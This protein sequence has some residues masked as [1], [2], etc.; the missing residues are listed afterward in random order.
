MRII[1]IWIIV[2]LFV[3]L[4]IVTLSWLSRGDVSEVHAQ[5]KALLLFG[6]KEHETFLG[7]L[8][9]TNT[10]A[11]SVCNAYGKNGSKYQSDSIWN[12][13][14]HFGSKYSSDSP[15]NE[16][17]SDAPIIVDKDGGSYGY[18]SENK[19]IRDRTRIGWLLKV[20]DYQDSK[21]DLDK[22]RDFMCND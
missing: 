5:A 7:C 12:A 14:G 17:S 3:G 13:Y 20:L 8:N 16:Y 10:S 18:L 22:T 2:G 1:R 11:T 4:S 9:C 21:D 15:W 19:Y 6:G